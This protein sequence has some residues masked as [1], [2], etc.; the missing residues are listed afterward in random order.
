[1]LEQAIWFGFGVCCGAV[2]A[3]AWAARI[4]Q[5]AAASEEESP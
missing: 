1:M 3:L 5:L 4:A 2:G